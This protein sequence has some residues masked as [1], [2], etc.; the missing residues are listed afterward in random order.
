MKEVTVL[1][2]RLAS[3]FLGP[4]TENDTFMVKGFKLHLLFCLVLGGFVSF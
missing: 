2:N 4:Q 3:V 1:C